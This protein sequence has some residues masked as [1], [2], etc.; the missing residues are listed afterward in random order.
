LHRY[1]YAY[2]NPTVYV[3]LNG[4]E[5]VETSYVNEDDIPAD[6]TY[7]E[8]RNKFYVVDREAYGPDDE[9]E[10]RINRRVTSNSTDRIKEKSLYTQVVELI[11]GEINDPFSDNKVMQEKSDGPG[12][13][14]QLTE[15]EQI[16][17]DLG[18]LGRAAER[19]A[20][21][22]STTAD[23][24]DVLV[25]PDKTDVAIG[26]GTL[27]TGLIASKINKLRK[28]FRG[29]AD[30][31]A[32]IGVTNKG[33]Y[34]NRTNVTRRTA[35]DVNAEFGGYRPPYRPGTRVTEYSTVEAEQFVRVHG[36]NNAA[37]SWMMKREAIEGL[38]PEDIARK[39]SLPEVPTRVSDVTV[40]AGA[41]MRTGRVAE[42]FDGNQGAIQYQW[43]ER[44]PESAISN[45][46]I[47]QGK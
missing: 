36:E 10:W 21:G 15:A 33:K 24:I 44:V 43:L 39:Y 14:E 42:N 6:V 41:R 27:G 34:A 16:E 26:I 2:S 23:V 46:Q 11:T 18:G 45:T 5:A 28:L 22:A 37:R 17:R 1:L 32:P 7:R 29:K 13:E 30:E 12:S 8:Y 35:D 38:S 20:D 40:P 47:L 31:V 9:T 3:D 25:T 19:F 4:Y